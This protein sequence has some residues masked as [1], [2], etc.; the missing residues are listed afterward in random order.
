MAPDR[1]AVLSPCGIYRYRL[2][3]RVG[4]DPRACNF[5]MLNP[6][7][8]DATQDD[9]TI[10]RCIAF[11]KGWGYGRLVVTNLFAYRATDPREMMTTRTPVVGPENNQHIIEAATAAAVTVCA[12]G[13]HGSTYGRDRAVLRLLGNA[14]IEPMALRV[15]KGGAPAHPLY[16]PATLQP[17]P[18]A[19]ARHD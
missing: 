19:E 2:D 17:V 9:P 5:L 18:L 6:S 1:D 10:R 13:A 14:G 11:A 3:R 7:T 4:D 8:A 15:T 16:L 12:W